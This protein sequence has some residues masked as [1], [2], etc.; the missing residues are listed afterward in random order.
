MYINHIMVRYTPNIGICIAL[1]TLTKR[2]TGLQHK[3]FDD[4]VKDVSVIITIPTVCHKI[5]YCFRTSDKYN[6]NHRRIDNIRE[7]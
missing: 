2:I 4:P 6:E 3:L 7:F 1:Y 5:L